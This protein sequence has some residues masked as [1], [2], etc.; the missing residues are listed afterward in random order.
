MNIS[1][2]SRSHLPDMFPK[3]TF[4]YLSPSILEPTIVLQK[5]LLL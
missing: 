5:S 3:K 2:W 4:I 1:T